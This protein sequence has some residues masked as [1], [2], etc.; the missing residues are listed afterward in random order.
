MINLF[1][2]TLNDLLPPSLK[3]D[4][5][6]LTASKVIDKEFQ[7]LTSYIKKVLTFADI[8]HA[9]EGVVDLLAVELNTDFYNNTLPLEVK[10]KLV[11]N[12]L[13][14][15]YTKGTAYALE[16]LIKELF[17]DGEVV[18]W[19]E[20]GG[21]PYYFKVLTTNTSVTNDEL[22]KFIKAVN[23]IK[24]TR[25]YLEKIEITTI[26]EMKLYFGNVLHIADYITIRQVN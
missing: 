16:L 4:L 12:A 8:D 19:F 1:E 23:A 18:E 14:Y 22:Q 21:K 3:D 9:D 5:D 11:K 13:I 25:S 26:D 7:A 20:Y 2:S 10:R 17:G 24:N 6:I 15:K